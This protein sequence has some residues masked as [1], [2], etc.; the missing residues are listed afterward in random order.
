[1]NAAPIFWVLGIIVWAFGGY[2]F[3]PQNNRFRIGI[4][5]SVGAIG[6]LGFIAGVII[7]ELHSDAVTK[8]AWMLSGVAYLSA[9]CAVV[10]RKWQN[11]K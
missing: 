5:V 3:H 11:R 8:V 6:P 9:V 1:M 4:F 2:Y 7:Q 10:Y